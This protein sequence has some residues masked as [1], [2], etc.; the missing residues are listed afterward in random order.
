MELVAIGWFGQMVGAL[1]LPF[2]IYA[3]RQAWLE[4]VAAGWETR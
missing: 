4:A 3:M 2:V 1:T